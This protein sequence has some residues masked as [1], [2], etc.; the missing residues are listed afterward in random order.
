MKAVVFGR[1]GDADVLSLGERPSSNPRKGEVRVRVTASALNPIDW[2]VRSG[3][4]AMM[5][6]WRFPHALGSDFAGVVVEVGPSVRSF[7]V[8]EEVFGGL[9]AMKG[10][11]YAEEL[12][13]PAS[14]IAKKP[15]GMSF[16]DAATLPVA[17][18][19]ALQGLRDLGRVG[20]G[21][22]VLVH[23]C[24]GGV[25]IFA[26]QIARR[27]GAHVTGT[28]SAANMD[29]ARELGADDV[30]DYRSMNL[31]EKAPFDVIFE[32]SG[33]APFAR[34]RRWLTPRGIFVNP[35]PTPA[36]LLGSAIGNLFRGQKHRCLL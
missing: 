13:A 21:T 12:T 7:A 20:Q 29:L 16:R 10:G 18:V 19:A 15:S 2:K 35:T 36:V 9:N 33:K 14:A 28:C 6:G 27:M 5:S 11:A 26:L 23:G 32:L 1:Y 24:T 4:M 34:A 25:G 17:G 8:G 3:E 22:R 31:D 30:V